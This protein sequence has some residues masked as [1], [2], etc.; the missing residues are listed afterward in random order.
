MWLCV[1]C[2]SVFTNLRNDHCYSVCDL[3]MP[4]KKAK[5]SKRAKKAAP[6]KKAPRKKAP[7]KP[8]KAKTTRKVSTT[9]EKKL[10]KNKRQEFKF[11]INKDGSPDKRCKPFRGLRK[12]K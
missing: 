5:A 6:K 12:R 11:N 7:K 1:L 4:P 8:K 2:V 3:T 10:K 9:K